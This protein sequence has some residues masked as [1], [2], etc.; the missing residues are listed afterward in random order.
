MTILSED[1]NL[2]IIDH[3][4]F[5]LFIVFLLDALL[6]VQHNGACGINEVDGMFSGKGVCGRRLSMSAQQ[7]LRIMDVSHLLVIDGHQSHLL[8]SI[9]LLTIVHNVT[10]AIELLLLGQFLFRLA[11]ST[12]HTKAE[13]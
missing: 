4:P 2:F 6:Q 1:D 13:P 5:H 7:H 11:D 9:T 10:Q 8:Q 12:R 3:C